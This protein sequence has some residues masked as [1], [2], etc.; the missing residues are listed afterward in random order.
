MNRRCTIRFLLA[1]AWIGVAIGA[2]ERARANPA[3]YELGS[4]PAVGFNL[5][6]WYN[7]GASGA[8]TWQNAV[9]GLYD[10]GFRSVSI[11]P[12]RF[13][14]INTG[15]ILATSPKGPELSHIEAGVARAKSLGMRVTLNPFVELFDPNGAGTGD[16][17][18]FANL[19][20]GCT[21][22]GCW[23][24]TAGSAVSN[25]FWS[26]YQNY[27]VAVAQIA[28]NNNV[29]A[30]TVGT[31]YKALDGNSAHNASWNTVINAID[32]TYAGPLGYAANWDDYNNSNVTS[33]IW[34]H[35]AIDF[36]GIDSYFTNLVSASQADASGTYPNATF[37]TAVTTAWNNKLN[38]QI[39]PFAAARKGG[40]GMPVAFTEVGYLPYNRTAVNPQN[41]SGQAVDADEQ[42][43]AFNGLI[44]ALDG[45][46]N[47]FTSLDIWQWGMSGSDGS[48]WN[49]DT[50]LPANQ[51]NNVSA[52]QWLASFVGT[53]VSPLAGDYNRDGSVDAA[54]YIAWRNNARKYALQYSG[55]D[56][57]G[58]GIVDSADYDVW[59]AHFA[60]PASG[61]SAATVPEPTAQTITYATLLAALAFCNRRGSA[62]ISNK[63]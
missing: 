32:A 26:D 17:E 46:G 41:S 50:T 45:R 9:Q 16:D 47:A 25:Q 31:E 13:V 7:F 14:N 2:R 36:I 60:A 8:S 58:N 54:D 21:W 28:A 51:P 6:S 43:M 42:K 4:D 55:A 63:W 5:I 33:A 61:S 40:A 35:P 59:R 39:L 37:V 15:Q 18:Y 20:S 12:V 23:N 56:G 27:L 44:N 10:A 24:P 11:S 57:N 34:E 3:V 30:M 52:A 62:R 53:A 38:N 49:M 1:L 48:L 19:P 29:D 22:R